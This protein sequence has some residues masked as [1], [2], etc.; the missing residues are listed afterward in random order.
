MSYIDSFEHV[1]VGYF[2]GLPGYSPAGTAFESTL[3][4]VEGKG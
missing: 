4:S 1:L 3:R 2:A